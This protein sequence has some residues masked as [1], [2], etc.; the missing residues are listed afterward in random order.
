MAMSLERKLFIDGKWRGTG[1]TMPVKSPYDGREVAQVHLGGEQE[2]EDATQAAVRAFKET[3]LLSRGQRAEILR[4]IA[5]GVARRK[6]EIAATMTDEMGKPI[7]YA[8]AEAARCVTTFTLAAEE[9]K[10]WTGE[11]VPVDIE[12]HTTGYYA[13]TVMVPLGPI[14]A[15]SPFN[16]PLNLVAHKLAPC[17]AVGSTMVLKPARQTPLEALTLAEIV[18]EAGAPPGTFNVVNCE[19][20]VGERLATDD[21]FPF[22]TF[23]G[24][25]GI[26]WRLKQKGWKK[27]VTLELGGNAA[28]I[29][30]SDADLDYAVQ[31]CLAGAFG[32]AGQ[33]CISVQRILIHEPLYAAFEKKFLDGVAKLKVGD[34]RDPETVVGPVIDAGN[35]D[36]ILSWI[37]EAKSAGAKILAGGTKEG[38]VVRPTVITD[39]A[40]S[41]KVSC[42][43]VFGPLVTLAR[44]REFE[45]AVRLADD[46]AYG[47][48]AGVF[49]HDIRQIRHAVQNLHV[50]GVMVNEVPTTRVDNMPY[51]GSRDS[52]LGREGPR[53]AMH[54]MSEPR[55]VMF[56]LDH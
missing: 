2:M 9:A 17:L 10:R 51:G 11:I 35:A 33:S 29:V 21:R 16:F 25:V 6:D 27:R 28:C 46:S 30:H 50:G 39:A 1:R 12:A 23:T 52:G 41:L 4:K 26:G 44:Y 5:E 32:Q 42:Q 48:Q 18:H 56:N 43:E 49:T 15:I 54:E 24:S 34:P 31:K 45:E 47:L 3:R 36:R 40:H 8:R 38:N 37:A 14:A 13:M 19:P 55:L 22:L 20:A 7:Q 53:Y